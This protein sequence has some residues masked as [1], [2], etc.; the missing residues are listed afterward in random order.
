MEIPL[1]VIRPLAVVD[2]HRNLT[3]D[4]P[5]RLRVVPWPDPVVESVGHHPRSLYV[6]T[7]WLPVLG[8]TSTWLLRRFVTELDVAADGIM[9][10]VHDTARALGLGGRQGKH[11]P[12]ARALQRCVTF[13][14]ARRYGPDVLAVRRLLPA[15]PRRHLVRLTPRLQRQHEAWAATAGRIP[16]FEGE[17]RRARRLALGL[18]E[19]GDDPDASAVQLLR[20]GVHPAL[21]DDAIAW[22]RGLSDPNSVNSASAPG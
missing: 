10:D 5:I 22:A 2:H 15:L 7:F 3:D 16:A 19:L 14:V 6:E 9:I 4:E 11:A 17:R 18:S 20:W 12:F 1:S 8:P 21:A 13:E